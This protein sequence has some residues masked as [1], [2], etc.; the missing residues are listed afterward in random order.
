MVKIQPPISVEDCDEEK[1]KTYFFLAL[2]LLFAVAYSLPFEEDRDG[3]FAS[4]RLVHTSIK[5][6]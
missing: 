3:N 5:C 6:R 2:G 1:M 4:L